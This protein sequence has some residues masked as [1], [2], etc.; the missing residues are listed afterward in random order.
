MGKKRKFLFFFMLFLFIILSFY[1]CQKKE[2]KYSDV[3]YFAEPI[4]QDFCTGFAQN[5]YK[6][7]AKYFVNYMSKPID[8][9][10]LEKL[11]SKI[12]ST[13]GSYVPG[14]ISYK[15]VKRI[16]NIFIINYTAKFTDENEPVNITLNFE[17]KFNEFK[18]AGFSLDSPKLRKD[19]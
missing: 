19:K 4:I 16:N 18:V 10:S 11:F 14:S 3:A 15:S 9:E 17:K 8:V 5:D 12:G 2:Y 7:F 13:I 1:S 6:E